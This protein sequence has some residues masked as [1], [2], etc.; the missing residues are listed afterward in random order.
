M[1]QFITKLN[2]NLTKPGDILQH[3]LTKGI[4]MFHMSLKPLNSRATFDSFCNCYGRLL[5]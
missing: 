5:Q 3:S 2:Q 4:S 1:I